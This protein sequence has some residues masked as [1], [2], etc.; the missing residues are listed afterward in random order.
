M[1]CQCHKRYHT[2]SHTERQL[3]PTN[4]KGSAISN[5]TADARGSSTAEFN[6]HFSFI[7]KTRNHILLATAIVVIQKKF[8]KYVPCRE[9]LD[10]VFQS[11]YLTEICVQSLRLK[12]P[13]DLHQYRAYPLLI[14]RKFSECH[15]I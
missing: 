15:Y 8:C 4:D 6:T 1:C 9:L 2:L 11:H 3:Q 7:S 14:L 13:R 5:P 10:S 12:E